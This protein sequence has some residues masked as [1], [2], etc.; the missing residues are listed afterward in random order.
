MPFSCGVL[1]R[2]AT[3]HFRG[4]ARGRTS[5]RLFLEWFL[6]TGKQTLP[7]HDAGVSVGVVS[8]TTLRSK[9]HDQRCSWLIA[10]LWLTSMGT[11]HFL[12]TTRTCSTGILGIDTA[13]DDPLVPRD[14]SAVPAD[15]SFQPVPAFLVRTL[16]VASLFRLQIPQLFEHEDRG[17][18]R[19]G[20]LDNPAT[21]EVSHL[22]V[23]AM[24][25]VP[26]M[27]SILLTL[28]TDPGRAA[29]AGDLAQE[30]LPTTVDLC[31][32]SE[33]SG[34]KRRAVRAQD[35]CD[36]QMTIQIQLDCTDAPCRGVQLIDDSTRTCELLGDGGMQPPGAC[37][38]DQRRGS[39]LPAFRSS[40]PP[41][42]ALD[43]GPG[44]TRPQLEQDRVVLALFVHACIQ[45]R[46]FVPRTRR[47]RRP[48]V[49]SFLARLGF[50]FLRTP[51]AEVAGKSAS[52]A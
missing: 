45:R 49:K 5:G 32:G 33:E 8:M 28:G 6:P 13:R 52:R 21:D 11:S 2:G 12:M 1:G 22:L 18:V 43:P 9:T 46:R 41:G 34:S 40:A 50:R 14:V 48:L 29:V 25:A 16:T 26:E 42:L 10:F 31:S 17:S 7:D 20:K 27:Q 36:R 23:E 15:A 38:L 44:R 3:L 24:H 47:H 4:P 37:L 30:R 51:C 19:P 39:G 35:G